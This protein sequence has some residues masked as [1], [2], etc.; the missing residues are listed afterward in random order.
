MVPLNY[1]LI[2]S[3]ILFAI[4]TAGVF[5]G[6]LVVYKTGAVRVTPR[7]T[8]WLM[9]AMVGVVVLM[10]A[11][12]VA[13]LFGAGA[14]LAALCWTACASSFIEEA[15]CSSAAASSGDGRHCSR[16]TRIRGT[17]RGP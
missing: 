3:G 9:G 2:L 4:G 8:K 14:A 13:G 6:M 5:V 11:N 10:I 16:R 12:L 15:V 17:A 1:Y 7:F